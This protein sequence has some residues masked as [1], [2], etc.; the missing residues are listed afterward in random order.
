MS[1]FVFTQK[2]YLKFSLLV[3]FCTFPSFSYACPLKGNLI[4][5][6]C[7]QQLRINATGDSI[8]SG[9]GDEINDNRGGYVKRLSSRFRSAQVQNIGVSGIT[10]MDLLQGYITNLSKEKVGK[11]KK[12][13]EACD[14]LII[15]VG[16]NDYFSKVEPGITVRNIARI[17]KY[18]RN[19]LRKTSQAEPVIGVAT[20]LPTT[21]AYQK[22]F[23]DEVNRLL[24]KFNS[25]A[26]PVHLRFDRV[27]PDLIS[28]DGLHPTSAGFSVMT[29]IVTRFIKEE[30]QT[31]AVSGRVD[32]DLDGVYDVF[33]KRKFQTDP[34]NEDTD[35]DGLADGLELFTYKTDPL[36]PDSDADGIFDSQEAAEGSTPG[37]LATPSPSPSETPIPTPIL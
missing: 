8:V 10:S 12:K 11:T 22:P 2:N 23:V 31:L 6:N 27:S 17:V 9:R 21:R 7:D 35:N 25:K 32:K 30:G 34:T 3:L 1:A 15:D 18:L 37:L 19:Y 16:R 28:E 26:L 4:D 20:L 5:R 14:Y 36:L 13:I 33:E 24:L 29:E